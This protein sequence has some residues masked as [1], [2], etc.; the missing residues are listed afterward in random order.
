MKNYNW[1]LSYLAPKILIL[2]WVKYYFSRNVEQR[3]AKAE[4]EAKI[5]FNF[6]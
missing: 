2:S 3:Q 5:N 4:L 6:D 1:F